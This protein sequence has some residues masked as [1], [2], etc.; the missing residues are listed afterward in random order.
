MAEFDLPRSWFLI[1]VTWLVMMTGSYWLGVYTVNYGL[2]SDGRLG[3]VRRSIVEEVQGGPIRKAADSPQQQ[4]VRS[5]RE[6]MKVVPS[7]DGPWQGDNDWRNKYFRTAD[8]IRKHISSVFKVDRDMVFFSDFEQDTEKCHKHGEPYTECRGGTPIVRQK[9]CAIVGSSG[10]VRDSGCGR[11]IDQHDFIMRFNFAPLEEFKNDVGTKV[12]LVVL[13]T[14]K[15]H[16]ITNS[17]AEDAEEKRKKESLSVKVQ[18]KDEIMTRLRQYNN[19]VIFYPKP[20]YELSMG[21]ATG[22][23][24][25]L[26]TLLE[27]LAEH[28]LRATMTYNLVTLKDLTVDLLQKLY[29]DAE[30]PSVGVI[31][32]LLALT[33]CDQLDLY[34]FYPLDYDPW[35]RTVLFHYH[36]DPL[37]GHGLFPKPHHYNTEYEFMRELD[38]KGVLTYH[39][40]KCT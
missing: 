34:G 20:L 6:Q 32:Y 11:Q 33:F 13:G 10:I 26:E 3:R 1:V 30:A 35:N 29:P 9:S 5:S 18:G 38:A 19:T 23:S 4:P 39:I 27:I 14:Y 16:I 21:V 25:R 31:A 15:L 22:P 40:D 8:D 37:P 2:D 7:P 17:F 24:L 36:D 12:N 28:Q